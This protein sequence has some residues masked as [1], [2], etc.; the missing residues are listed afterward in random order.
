GA[1]STGVVELTSCLEDGRSLALSVLPRVRRFSSDPAPVTSPDSLLRPASPHS[2]RGLTRGVKT[3]ATLSRG[4]VYSIKR[5]SRARTAL[6]STTVWDR[7]SRTC[8]G[9][10]IVITTWLFSRTLSLRRRPVRSEEHTSELQSLAYL[11]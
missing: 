3:K 7:A 8:E 4:C 6:T 5:P 9:S 2:C 10:A 1:S 11:V